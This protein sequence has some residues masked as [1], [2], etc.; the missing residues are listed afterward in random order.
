MQR[1]PDHT[2]CVPLSEVDVG[3]LA[4]RT[5]EAMWRSATLAA[6]LAAT[7]ARVAEVVEK[8][9][10]TSDLL[11]TRK[12]DPGP[13]VRHAGAARAYAARERQQSARFAAVAARARARLTA[14]E[15]R[16]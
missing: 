16:A 10:L 11:A 15:E 14:Y 13:H 3:N 6:D 9:A 8:V 4:D 1:H 2:K 7:A 5:T 12:G